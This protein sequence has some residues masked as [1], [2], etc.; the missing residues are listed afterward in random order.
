VLDETGDFRH[1]ANLGMVDLEPLLLDGDVEE[2][3]DLLRRHVRYTESA[4]AERIL[5]DWK[6]AQPRFVKIMPRDYKRALA[7]M[8]RAREEGIPWERAVMEGAHG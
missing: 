2:V 1:R 5:V 4:V 8:R 6:A 7:A 3:R